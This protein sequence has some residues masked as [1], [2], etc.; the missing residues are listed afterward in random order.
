M[1]F[2]PD[3]VPDFPWDT[4]AE[5]RRQA[6]RYPEGVVDL[7]IGTPVDDTPAMIQQ[8]LA[9]ASNAP[10]YPPAIGIERL[11]EEIIRWL[12]R[13]R[14]ITSSVGVIPTLGSKELVGLLPALLG[15]A[16]GSRIGI[17]AI[18]YPTY[19]VGARLAGC[20]PVIV[21]TEAD[22]ASWPTDLALLWVNSPSNPSGHVLDVAQLRAIVA[23]AR[24]NGVII[25]S[26]ECYAELC[27]DVPYSPSLLADEV[28]GGDPSQLLMLYSLS[29]QSNLAGYR[30]AFM[31]GD[32]QLVAGVIE[33][34]KHLGFMMPT[35][36]QQAMAV[37]L[38]DDEHVR[39]QRERYR[40]RR[41]VLLQAMPEAGL[42]HDPDSVA[43]LYVWARVAQ[44]DWACDGWDI[45]RACAQLG[46]VVAPGHFYGDAGR[47]WVRMSL[48]ASDMDIA[49][50]AERLNLLSH[51]LQN[52]I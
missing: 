21:D 48:T 44:A 26:D 37:A 10:G 45:V 6:A 41:E 49:R 3:N 42:R 13:R 25:A 12:A 50:A 51:L 52:A 43:G 27:W 40:R 39:V 14:G 19:E 46:I 20:E 4:L 36:V 9:Q 47:S 17:P 31:A 24:A 1:T 34:R 15:I 23:W 22:P 29:K 5:V 7:T 11:R 33:L 38:A 18:A 8:V 32:S 30:A 35:P 16:V 2:Y 28:C